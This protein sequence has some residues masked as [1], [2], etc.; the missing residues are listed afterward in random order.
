MR[1]D[2]KKYQ[3]IESWLRENRTSEKTTNNCPRFIASCVGDCE[4]PAPKS[5]QF[6]LLSRTMA[7]R[8]H[9]EIV[10]QNSTMFT[11]LLGF[12]R[13]PSDSLPPQD[14]QRILPTPIRVH[15]LSRTSNIVLT[16]KLIHSTLSAL[17]TGW[18]STAITIA[19][20][21]LASEDWQRGVKTVQDERNI[22][23]GLSEP[24]LH[25]QATPQRRLCSPLL[26]S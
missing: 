21:N 17:A 25:I 10:S 4:L 19:Y 9:T 26:L 16:G 20:R 8:Q 1:Q 5:N 13:I 12:A 7:V 11:S 15:H 14:P 2:Y 3:R 24:N 6:P 18:Q 22:V 23:K